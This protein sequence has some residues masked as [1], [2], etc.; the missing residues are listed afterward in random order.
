MCFMRLLFTLSCANA[1]AVVLSTSSGKR[2]FAY[3]QTARI[4]K[5][6]GAY[7][8]NSGAYTQNRAAYI[9]K[10]G[11]RVYAT[12]VA[13][14]RKLIYAKSGARIRKPALRVYANRVRVHVYANA[15]E[16]ASAI[17]AC[18]SLFP[19]PGRAIQVIAMS[20]Y[21]FRCAC[22]CASYI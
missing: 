5:I 21:H 4:S 13:Y 12:R 17:L 11:W 6:C 18:Y 22:Q 20:S 7:T 10:I 9:R 19:G 14:I 8:Q 3:S 15:Y 1:I 16:Y 2:F